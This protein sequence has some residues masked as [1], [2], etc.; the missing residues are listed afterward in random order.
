MPLFFFS[1]FK[2]R[3]EQTGATLNDYHSGTVWHNHIRSE[4]WV[5]QDLA[6]DRLLTAVR[7]SLLSNVTTPSCVDCR[8]VSEGMEGLRCWFAW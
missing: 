6:E 2:L 7:E 5:T 3:V 1:F 8:D 4:L